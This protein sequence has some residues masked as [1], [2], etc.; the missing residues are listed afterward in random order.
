MTEE[1]ARPKPIRCSLLVRRITRALVAAL[2]AYAA[3]ESV[4]AEKTTG[5]APGGTALTI[6]FPGARDRPLLAIPEARVASSRVA[7][8]RRLFDADWERG[9]PIAG[10]LGPH[11]DQSSC[12]GCHSESTTTVS[13]RGVNDARHP[14][15]VR[16]ARLLDPAS[17][18]RHGTQLNMDAL[19]GATP[20]GRLQLH[21]SFRDG[22]F[23]DGTRYRLSYPKPSVLLTSPEATGGPVE[24]GPVG[25]RIA[26][27]LFGWGLL[28]TVSDQDLIR[29]ADPQ[30]RTGNGISGRVSWVWDIAENR[31]AI[32][33]FGWK[34]EQPNLRQQIAAALRNDM[35][36]TTS[37]FP[38]ESCERDPSGCLAELDDALLEELVTYL[39][40]VGV[41]DRR[42]RDNPEVRRGEVLFG[43]IGC[44][45]C[46]IPVLITA[47]HED[48][49]LSEQIIWPYTDLLLHDMGSA[50]AD[51]NA[52]VSPNA[53]EWRTAPLWGI[54][55]LERY[56]PGRP[57]L[58]DGRARSLLEAVLWHG[59]EAESAKQRVLAMDRGDRAALIAFLRS[60]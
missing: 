4:H 32:G 17:R 48:A 44:S 31:L 9:V 36:I 33:R 30:D 35:G 2:V 41:P 57:F 6:A 11:F 18:S 52:D 26:P 3:P 22:R 49:V 25:L 13:N 24:L 14:E 5:R 1:N 47:S 21:Y 54:G 29:I 55:L 10:I 45:D 27:A 34:A 15:P 12:S 56:V 60:L 51:S 28:G 58:H 39:R 46:H 37:L 42:R 43:H 50:L 23:D 40:Y 20:K 16:I 7:Y 53:R 59:G 19:P 8:G 38:D